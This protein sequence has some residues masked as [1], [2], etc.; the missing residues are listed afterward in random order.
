MADF[1]FSDAAVSKWDIFRLVSVFQFV[2]QKRPFFLFFFFFFTFLACLFSAFIIMLL[3]SHMLRLTWH[4]LCTS[5][6]H[7]NLYTRISIQG[8][9]FSVPSLLPLLS[10]FLFFLFLRYV[11]FLSLSLCSS[12]SFIVFLVFLSCAYKR[13]VLGMAPRSAPISKRKVFPWAA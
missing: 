2:F 12:P 7:L 9:F 10:F 4:F 3:L 8:V 1:L 13:S 11:L 6:T 5:K